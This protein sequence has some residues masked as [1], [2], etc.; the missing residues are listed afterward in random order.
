MRLT[1]Q[2]YFVCCLIIATAIIVLKPIYTKS[3]ANMPNAFA[4]TH[5]TIAT[6]SPCEAYE[7]L[8]STNKITLDYDKTQEPFRFYTITDYAHTRPLESKKPDS[9][10]HI[11]ALARNAITAPLTSLKLRA[12]ASDMENIAFVAL[13]M[14]S[15]S[16]YIPIDSVLGNH[17]LDLVN[18][19]GSQTSS[20]VSPPKFTKSYESTTTKQATA[21]QGEAAAGFFRTPRILEEEK[22]AGRENSASSSSRASE[23]SVAIH[24]ANADSRATD[25][26]LDLSTYKLNATSEILNLYKSPC[27]F[28]SWLYYFLSPPFLLLW[29]MCVWTFIALK[30]KHPK[31]KIPART[32]QELGVLVLLLLLALILRLYHYDSFGLWG[33][34]LYSVGVVG[35]PDGDF[36]SVFNDPGNPPF[37]NFLLKLWLHCFG[38]TSA[39]ARGL[40]VVIGTMGVV[41]IYLLLRDHA[42]ENSALGNH[43]SDFVDFLKKHRLTPSGVPCFKA[44]ADHKSSS[45]LKSTKSPTSTTAIPRILEEEK[46]AGR[47]NSASS[48]LRA[49]LRKAWQSISAQADSK[50]AQNREALESTFLQKVDSSGT[51]ISPSLRA[52]GEA[53]QGAAAVS[54]VIHK[55]KL[56]SSM[57]CHDFASAKSRNDDETTQTPTPSDSNTAPNV[58]ELAK[59]SRILELESGFFKRVQGR[60]LGV[61]NR[62]T[63]AEI[64]DSSPKA[65]SSKKLLIPTLGAFFYAIS[66]VAIGAAHEV[67]GYVL[68]LALLPLVFYFLLHFLKNPKLSNALGYVLSG[69]MVCNTHYFGAVM[70][71][72][73]FIASGF[74]VYQ[75]TTLSTRKKRETL[76]LVLLLDMLITSSLVPFFAITAYTQA[77]SDT[78]FNTWIPAPSLNGLLQFLPQAFG[79]SSGA[80]VFLVLFMLTPLLKNR[81]LNF[82]AIVIALGVLLP[83]IASFV[84]PIYY[85]KYAIYATYAFMLALCSVGIVLVAR[86]LAGAQASY[87]IA[88]G[89]CALSISLLDHKIQPIGVGDNARAKFAFITQDSSNE[90][91]K[92]SINPRIYI[93]DLHTAMAT[94]QRQYEVY[95][96][97]PRAEFLRIGVP[98]LAQRHFHTGDI[99][100][101]DGYFVEEDTL[102]DLLETFA[103]KGARIYP[104][105]FG[106]QEERDLRESQDRIY[107]VRF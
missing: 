41:G 35:Y 106:I 74:F 77:L 26:T 5:I 56:E 7:L 69:A 104:I 70:I 71:A 1:P 85:P 67:R 32:Y 63:H 73:G 72:A 52:K 13:T 19:G 25:I 68:E 76:A 48:S 64:H 103:S 80:F 79:S 21:V 45:A 82:C 49:L 62:S 84:R 14:G 36:S 4:P 59:D 83:F 47:E 105:P 98:E 87:L 28:L 50:K 39:A 95:G 16:F 9:S 6:Q 93:I 90:A 60:I 58:S 33:D 46:G 78:S 57:D 8:A 92:S 40:S 15:E 34:E 24:S 10:S 38:Y 29:L 54:L 96:F 91:N 81:F 42:C 31:G 30:P 23:A 43:S 12:N 37:Y 2:A 51:A 11:C 100:Y 53:K 3:Y 18:F 101:L 55:D 102:Q 27:T 107:K 99:L 17:S 61:C 66:F 20:L 97:K 22:G 86:R 44:T 94:K 75:D 88:F 89:V 65:Q